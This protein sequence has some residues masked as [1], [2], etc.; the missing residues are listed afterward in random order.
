[1]IKC[2]YFMGGAVEGGNSS[3]VAEFNI[4][5]DPEA[6]KIV[7]GSGIPLVMVGLDAVSYTHLDV[8]KRQAIPFIREVTDS[9]RARPR[10]QRHWRLR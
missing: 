8:Y 7:F 9:R 1:M 10:L 2:I 6:A 4:F 5:F 3:A